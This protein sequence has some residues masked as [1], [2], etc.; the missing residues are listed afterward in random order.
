M[1][2]LRT[3]QHPNGD[4]FTPVNY[5]KCDISGEEICEMNPHLECENGIHISDTGMEEI[6]EAYVKQMSYFMPD[7]IPFFL[8]LL[9]NKFTK[10]H[11]VDRYIPKQM[12]EE[13]LSKYQFKC[14]E[15]GV[16]EKLEIDHIKPISKG[17]ITE[18]SNLQVLCKKHN[19]KKSNKYSVNG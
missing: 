1:S 15:C 11:R 2:F 5:Y 13:I 12:R 7:G 9:E 19:I 10:K 8:R 17:G 4:D 16:T 18:L 14:V 3:E 6:I